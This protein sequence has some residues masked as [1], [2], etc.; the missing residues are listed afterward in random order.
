MGEL[1]DVCLEYMYTEQTEMK[2][3]DSLISF[4]GDQ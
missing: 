3:I 4:P 1:W 2:M